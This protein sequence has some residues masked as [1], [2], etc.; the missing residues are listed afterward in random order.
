MKKTRSKFAAVF[1][2][3]VAT[4]AIKERESLADLSK[5]FEVHPTGSV[6][7]SMNSRSVHLSYLKRNPKILIQK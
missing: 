7:G 3:K 1:K 5:R 2:A 6:S 4:E